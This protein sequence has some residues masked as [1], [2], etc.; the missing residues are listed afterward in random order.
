MTGRVNGSKG[1][2]VDP[3]GIVTTC[4]RHN[5]G[6]VCIPANF[7]CP[8]CYKELQAHVEAMAMRLQAWRVWGVDFGKAYNALQEAF[9]DP[10]GGEPP[11]ALFAALTEQVLA[12]PPMLQ[13][14]PPF[15]TDDLPVH[16]A[17]A[18]AHLT[19]ALQWNRCRCWWPGFPEGS[20]PNPKCVAARRPYEELLA[21]IESVRR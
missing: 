9:M 15:K 7:A 17:L 13:A 21:A 11:E 5:F 8:H 6:S 14:E 19:K 2:E 16:L 3:S 20:C 12:L 18:K 1:Q 4:R 10:K